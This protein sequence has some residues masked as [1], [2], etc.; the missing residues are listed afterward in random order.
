MR[1][2]PERVGVFVHVALLIQHATCTRYIVTTF[3]APL[4]LPYSLTPNHKRHDFRKKKIIEHKMRVLVFSTTFVQHI[5]HS[6]NLVRYQ[7]CE[8]FFM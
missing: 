3:L 2:V 8:N 6:K 7:K 4:A 1:G 5:P